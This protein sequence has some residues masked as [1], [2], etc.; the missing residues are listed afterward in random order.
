VRDQLEAISRPRRR[1]LNTRDAAKSTIQQLKVA[2]GALEGPTRNFK[3]GAADDIKALAERPTRRGVRV[4]D[5]EPALVKAERQ[6]QAF[7]LH[8]R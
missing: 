6:L 1:F 5:W 4:G 8:S 3:P 7:D 2:N